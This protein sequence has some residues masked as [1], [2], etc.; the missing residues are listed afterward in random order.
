M[1]QF[2]TLKKS[3]HEIPKG[4][5]FSIRRVG[6][7]DGYDG[8][9]LRAFYYF[10][11]QM[12]G[13]DLS[14]DS[15]NSIQTKYKELR[16]E[17]KG[18]TF[19][20]TYGGTYHGLMKNLGWPEDKAK[21]IEANY[22]ELY[23]VSTQWV[24]EK[25]AAAATDGYVTGAFGLRVRTPMLKQVIRG[26]KATPYEAE[27]EGR[28]AGNA[29]GQSY[30]LLNSRAGVEFMQFVR[31]SKYRHCIRPCAQIHDAQYY[32]VRDD[33]ELL[34]WMNEHL[35]L[36]V[37]WQELPE[38]QHDQVKLSGELAIFHPTWANEIT[39]PNGADASTIPQL[40]QQAINKGKTTSEPRE[41]EA[42]EPR[43]EYS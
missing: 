14:V 36:C 30:C 5:K 4:A 22:H 32:L 9:S 41:S 29:L 39:I 21:A 18:P 25:L 12:Q 13:I 34:G 37:E 23:K 38:I 7:T 27:A 16:Q 28:T 31:Q 2:A 6:N 19:L 24:Q 33:V 43:R 17:S 1:S 10:G 40:V 15:I 8:H 11:D 20:L 35:V 3:T 42:G 26:T